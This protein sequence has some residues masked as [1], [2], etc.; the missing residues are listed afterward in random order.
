MYIMGDKNPFER[1]A[2]LDAI[3]KDKHNGA[4][5]ALES[6]GNQAVFTS[7]C[8]LHTSRISGAVPPLSGRPTTLLALRAKALV[9]T[10]SELVGAL[11]P[12]NQKGCK[13]NS[14]RFIIT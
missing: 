5:Q 11:S 9:K 6:I 13:Q 10:I 3:R 14:R 7:A 4:D 2:Q 8:T 1:C 12:V